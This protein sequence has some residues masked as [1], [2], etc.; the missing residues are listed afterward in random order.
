[1]VF[2]ASFVSILGGC[3]AVSGGLIG[4]PV[5]WRMLR[6]AWWSLVVTSPI[7]LAGIALQKILDDEKLKSFS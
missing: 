4:W 5:L 2:V 3:G 7:L 1:M 6:V